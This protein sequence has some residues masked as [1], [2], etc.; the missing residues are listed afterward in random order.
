MIRKLLACAVV[1]LCVGVIAGSASAIEIVNPNNGHRGPTVHAVVPPGNTTYA[2]ARVLAEWVVGGFGFNLTSTV[3]YTDKDGCKQVWR[4][5]WR[6]P[7]PVGEPVF[8][9]EF[10]RK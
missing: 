3:E 9:L 8:L 6:G 10:C 2:V 7:V 4:Q 5:Y 1:V